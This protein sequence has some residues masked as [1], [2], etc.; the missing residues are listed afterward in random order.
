MSSNRTEA[1]AALESLLMGD[2]KRAEVKEVRAMLDS[3]TLVQVT[4]LK[5]LVVNELAKGK[6]PYTEGEVLAVMGEQ[7]AMMH[8]RRK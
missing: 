2:S 1:T 8:R 7:V 5:H 4:E 3:L 6:Q